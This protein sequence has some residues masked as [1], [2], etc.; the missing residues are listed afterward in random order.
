MSN[1]IVKVAII[2]AVVVV[3]G[4]FFFWYMSPY[5]QCIR[6]ISEKNP[7]NPAPVTCLRIMSDNN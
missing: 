6:T 5:Q 2:V 1:N 7:T 4:M 3:I